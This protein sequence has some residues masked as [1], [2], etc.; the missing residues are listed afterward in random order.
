MITAITTSNLYNIREYSSG[1]TIYD[2]YP[3][4]NTISQ[5]GV[6]FN[7]SILTGNTNRIVYY[8]GGFKYI[9][10]SGETNQTVVEYESFGYSDSNNFEQD[11]I[12]IK[13]ESIQNIISKPKKNSD[14]DIT[15]QTLSVYDKIYRLESINKLSDLIFYGGGTVFKIKNN[16]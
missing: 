4:A 11:T 1:S 5:N 12:D 8:I 2:L 6:D 10:F 16:I 7:E 15:R 13:D 3:S 9:D 14:V